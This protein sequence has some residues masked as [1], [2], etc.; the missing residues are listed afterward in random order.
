MRLNQLGCLNLSHLIILP[1]PLTVSSLSHQS[2]NQPTIRPSNYISLLIT[3]HR[4]YPGDTARSYCTARHL[5][6]QLICPAVCPSVCRTD[7]RTTM[8]TT[9][10]VSSNFY[11]PLVAIVELCTKFWN[12]SKPQTTVEEG[13][14]PW[15]QRVVDT[16]LRCL[17]GRRHGF[18]S[19]GQILR[20]KRA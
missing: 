4:N 19:G 7:L 15:T 3:P 6:R 18:E 9:L 17:Q 14:R 16:G 13:A 20:A 11:R 5:L 10:N 8:P 2:T 1:P 12:T